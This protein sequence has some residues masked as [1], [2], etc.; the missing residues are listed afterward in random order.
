VEQAGH[1]WDTPSKGMADGL[2][3]LAGRWGLNP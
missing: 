2:A 3:F 1:S